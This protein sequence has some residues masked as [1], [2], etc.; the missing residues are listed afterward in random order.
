MFFSY[1]GGEMKKIPGLFFMITTILAFQAGADITGHVADTVSH[2]SL[3]NVKVTL[4]GTT[5]TATTDAQGR[6]TLATTPVQRRPV[7]RP[8]VNDFQP[9]I[10][11]SVLVLPVCKWV[12]GVSICNAGGRVIFH[13]E[14][15]RSRVC[16]LPRFA[17]GVYFLSIIAEGV[18]QTFAVLHS[19]AGFS[20]GPGEKQGVSGGVLEK[21][22]AGP[23]T[24]AVS[25]EIA[26][27][28]TRETNVVD[29]G[30]NEIRLVPSSSTT[31]FYF[32]PV[33]LDDDIATATLA[34][35]S[36]NQTLMQNLG[37]K[38]LNKVN[39]HE[40]HSIL[41]CKDNKLVYEEYFFGN[42][43]T[44]NFE[45][46]VARVSLPGI[47]WTRTM[48]HYVA[49]TTK[50]FTST[51]VGMA[52][53]Q[54]GLTADER[55]SKYFP[56]Y[57]SLFTGDKSNILIKNCLNMQSGLNWN[58]WGG[59]D[60]NNMWKSAD[61]VQFVFSHDTRS[62]P[63]TEWVYISGLPNV[64][65]RLVQ[66]MLGDSTAKFIRQNMLEPLGITDIKWETQPGG[67][68]PEGAARLFI[69]P[70]DM[71]KWG[72]TCCNG[73]KWKDKQIIPAAWLTTCQSA[74]AGGNYSYHFWV[75]QYTYSGKTVNEFSAEGD[76]GNYVCMFPSIN[77]V[78]VFTGGLYL[79]SPTYDNQIRDVLTNFILPA[80]AP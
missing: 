65:M 58:E 13:A 4:I 51:V 69:R 30:V 24:Y 71:M 31:Y 18:R 76:G 29:T 53:A 36:A 74:Q 59:P 14:N 28:K 40:I 11:G 48:K 67:I 27:Y 55:V 34:S 56:T 5:S 26:N 60:L 17:G 21:A 45:N 47:Q 35:A 1:Q 41:V 52:L 72:L 77:V 8:Q 38:V 32:P 37:T 54:K 64:E 7:Q 23:N 3:A 10:T 62:A 80:V 22:Q 20:F 75:K 61:F 73:G 46:N 50:A 43:D 19:G 33:Q 39:C 44:I 57:S 42:N 15:T 16:G 25:C 70:R 78:V 9:K 66:N 6:F 79:E 12:V 63:G 2:Q 49:S 68:C